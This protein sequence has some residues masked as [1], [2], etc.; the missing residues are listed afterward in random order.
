MRDRDL[1][2]SRRKFLAS[3][4]ALTFRGAIPLARGSEEQ[5]PPSAFRTRPRKPSIEGRKPIA[6]V[7]TVY[8]PLAHAQHI[9]GR[10]INGYTLDGRFH[11]P[12]HFVKSMYVDQMPEN[13]LARDIG[14][15]SPA[16]RRQAH[17]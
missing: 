10:F 15:G 1:R 4:A 6:V 5:V 3:A 17:G 2:C 13:D 14:I 7:C 11:V 9:A 12:N 16:G 8:R